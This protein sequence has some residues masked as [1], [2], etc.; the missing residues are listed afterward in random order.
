MAD[1]GSIGA[2]RQI[3]VH[4]KL[5]VSSKIYKTPT[6]SDINSLSIDASG[7]DRKDV[8]KSVNFEAR[9]WWLELCKAQPM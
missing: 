4:E 6:P 7:L 2:S 3:I 8:M 1:L 5:V 9:K